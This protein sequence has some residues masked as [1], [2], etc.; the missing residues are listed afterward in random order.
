MADADLARGGHRG[1]HAVGPG[2]PVAGQQP[3]RLDLFDARQ[4]GQRFIGIGSEGTDLRTASL[5]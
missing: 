1:S 3:V 5:G 4:R 2:L